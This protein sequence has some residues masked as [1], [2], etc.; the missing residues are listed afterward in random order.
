MPQ[1]TSK[2]L[3]PET[4]QEP[5]PNPNQNPNPTEAETPPQVPASVS[6][7][8][9]RITIDMPNTSEAPLELPAL[10][11]ETPAEPTIA[12]ERRAKA[13]G[14]VTVTPEQIE[15]ILRM[16]G[17]VTGMGIGRYP[18]HWTWTEEELELVAP[19]LARQATDAARRNETLRR[20]FE[21]SDL[22][23]AA[24]GILAYVIR[25]L[26]TPAPEETNAQSTHPQNHRSTPAA[27]G[28]DGQ[29]DGQLDPVIH[30][31]TDPGFGGFPTTS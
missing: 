25:N 12:P 17:T 6:T 18:G 4:N 31:G 26:T 7:D 11:V 19:A 2:P 13:S 27:S 10:D 23:T 30:P 1:R 28:T 29:S 24:G 9:S 3:N 21:Q 16:Q 14:R 22:V 5:N 8:D 20:V 15:G